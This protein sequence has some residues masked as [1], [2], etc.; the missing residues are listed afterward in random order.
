MFAGL[1]HVIVWSALAMVTLPLPLYHCSWCRQVKDQENVPPGELVSVSL[2]NPA[3]GRR[4]ARVH[5][6]NRR[7]HSVKIGVVGPL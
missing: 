4:T 6:G 5:A 2:E 7:R 3:T 1:A